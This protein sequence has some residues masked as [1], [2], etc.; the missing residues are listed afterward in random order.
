VVLIH[1]PIAL[2]LVGVLF[3]FIGQWTKKPLL[4]DVAYYDLLLAAIST[5]PVVMTGLLAW[6]WQLEGQRLKGVLLLHLVLGLTASGMIC[7]VWS[8]HFRAHRNPEAKLP[9]YRVPIELATAVVVSLT[10]HLG[11]FLSGVNGSG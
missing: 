2:C 1:F 7:L 10:A 4:V 6:H 9:L 3:D 5:L 8:L 11:G